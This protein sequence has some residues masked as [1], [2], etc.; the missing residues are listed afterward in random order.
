MTLIK[1]GKVAKI[2]SSKLAR[3]A[4][5]CRFKYLL[6][7]EGRRKKNSMHHFILEKTTIRCCQ[8][9]KEMFPPRVKTISKLRNNCK[10]GFHKM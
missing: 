7:W 6:R 8:W 2:L 9:I 4:Q 10:K 1:K 3:N 5:N